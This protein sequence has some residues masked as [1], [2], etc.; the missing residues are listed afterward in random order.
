MTDFVVHTPPSLLFQVVPVPAAGREWVFTI[1]AD[2]VWWVHSV[3]CHFTAGLGGPNR[4]ILLAI[5]D[6]TVAFIDLPIQANI[7][8]G[9][10]RH[11]TWAAGTVFVVDTVTVSSTA[12]LPAPLFLPA[13][14][15]LQTATSNLAGTDQYSNIY[16]YYS[17][18]IL[19]VDRG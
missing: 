16:I 12:P 17:P 4:G 2:H 14:Y 8:G 1:P 7:P 15:S 5:D 10:P 18:F 11:F 13:G 19:P 3:H 6:G 9:T